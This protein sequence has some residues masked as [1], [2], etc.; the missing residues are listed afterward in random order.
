MHISTVQGLLGR[1]TSAH[2]KPEDMQLKQR[3][4]LT[5]GLIVYKALNLLPL[6]E[7]RAKRQ[8]GE[9]PT[10]AALCLALKAET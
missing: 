10:R 4:S 2:A 1:G 5:K 8:W 7:S 6:G 9:T 3:D